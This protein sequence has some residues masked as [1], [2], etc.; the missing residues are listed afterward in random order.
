MIDR[1]LVDKADVWIGRLQ[2]RGMPLPLILHHS[3]MAMVVADVMAVTYYL[4]FAPWSSGQDDPFAGLG[5]ILALAGLMELPRIARHGKDAGSMDVAGVRERYRSEAL[6]QR[7]AILPRLGRHLMLMLLPLALFIV[8]AVLSGHG[9]GGALT[10]FLVV[11]TTLVQDYARCAFPRQPNQ[12]ARQTDLA[13]E[14]A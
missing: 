10:A 8:W 7:E 11:V 12:P 14:G 2:E 13:L 1:W 6:R 3:G 9:S 4:F 5:I